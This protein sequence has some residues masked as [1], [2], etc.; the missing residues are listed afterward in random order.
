MSTKKLDAIYHGRMPTYILDEMRRQP[1]AGY[2]LALAVV[3]GLPGPLGVTIDNIPNPLVAVSITSP[4][5]SFS[6]VFVAVSLFNL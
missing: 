4:F 1:A 6:R 5:W 3:G 2:A